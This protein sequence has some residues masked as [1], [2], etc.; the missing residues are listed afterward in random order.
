VAAAVLG[1]LD[2]AGTVDEALRSFEVWA[3]A[4]LGDPD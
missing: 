3:E 4:R 2:G 1:S